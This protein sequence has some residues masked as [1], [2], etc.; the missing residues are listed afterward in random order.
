MHSGTC[1][2]KAILTNFSNS[3]TLESTLICLHVSFSLWPRGIGRFTWLACSDSRVSLCLVHRA[4][5]SADLIIY[6]VFLCGHCPKPSRCSTP[7]GQ[8]LGQQAASCC[9]RHCSV[10]LLFD[11]PGKKSSW[12][13]YWFAPWLDVVLLS[14]EK[15]RTTGLSSFSPSSAFGFSKIPSSHRTWDALVSSP[16]SV[17]AAMSRSPRIP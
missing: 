14:E 13:Y 12:C 16:V 2:L 8:G 10:K 5:L 6:C 1:G 17:S 3:T 9:H 11:T 15:G 4:L 7:S